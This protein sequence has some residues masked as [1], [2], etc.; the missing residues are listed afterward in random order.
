MYKR[1]SIALSNGKISLKALTQL[2]NK[3]STPFF[4][5]QSPKMP[6]L[7][8]F[9]RGDKTRV[10]TYMRRELNRYTLSISGHRVGE[11]RRMIGQQ[12][13]NTESR[14]QRWHT[15]IYA[16]FLYSYL[17]AMLPSSDMRIWLSRWSSLDRVSPPCRFSLCFRL[18]TWDD[19]FRTIRWIFKYL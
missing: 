2:D 4:S 5:A 18:Y 15:Y 17:C 10:Y 11:V 8:F 6:A 14:G 12:K 7:S 16:C 3:A 13:N 1:Q 9:F 19:F